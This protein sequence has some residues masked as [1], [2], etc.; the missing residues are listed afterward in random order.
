MSE[1]LQQHHYPNVQHLEQ[2]TTPSADSWE[3]FFSLCWDWWEEVERRRNAK[4]QQA[5]ATNEAEAENCA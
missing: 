4:R 3:V 2:A 5:E 1:P